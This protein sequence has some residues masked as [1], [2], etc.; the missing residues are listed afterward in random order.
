VG[1]FEVRITVKEIRGSGVCPAGHKIGEAVDVACP[2]PGNTVILK[3]ERGEP[4]KGKFFS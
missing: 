4:K 2:D 3:L 1:D